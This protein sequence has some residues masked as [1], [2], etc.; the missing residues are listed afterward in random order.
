M[1]VA[2]IVAWT[3]AGLIAFELF[4]RWADDWN[5]RQNAR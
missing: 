3:I 1:R 2:K 4:L 5:I